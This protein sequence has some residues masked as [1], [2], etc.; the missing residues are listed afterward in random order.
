MRNQS[1]LRAIAAADRRLGQRG[2]RL[3]LV[4]PQQQFMRLLKAAKLTGY[5][6]VLPSLAAAQA[7]L[8]LFCRLLLRAVLPGL[9]ACLPLEWRPP[10]QTW[11]SVS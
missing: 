3:G 11:G 9:V 10:G 7:S 8:R 1:G 6:E 2:G 5:F 4:A